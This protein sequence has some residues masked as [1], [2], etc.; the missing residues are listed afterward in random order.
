LVSADL[1]GPGPHGVANLLDQKVDFADIS[2]DVDAF[3][4]DGYPFEM[5]GCSP[6]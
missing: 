3:K 4:G 2:S 5:T 6:Q 1:R